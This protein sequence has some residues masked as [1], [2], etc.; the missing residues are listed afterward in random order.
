[1]GGWRVRIERKSSKKDVKTESKM[2]TIGIPFEVNGI[3]LEL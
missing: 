1:M 2:S 3:H